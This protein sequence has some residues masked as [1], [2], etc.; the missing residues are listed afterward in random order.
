ML[1]IEYRFCIIA[2]ATYT[3]QSCRPPSQLGS[4]VCTTWDL[5]GGLIHF[6][7]PQN[8]PALCLL[9]TSLPHYLTTS[10]PQWSQLYWFLTSYTNISILN[11]WCYFCARN[12]YDHL[13]MVFLAALEGIYECGLRCMFFTWDGNLAVL[14]DHAEAPL[15]L[16]MWWQS[17]RPWKI[18]LPIQNLLYQKVR[19]WQYTTLMWAH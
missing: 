2:P 5:N 14:N 3:K 15:G 13:R 4:N 7:L 11:F 10:L 12:H 17:S 1:V 6:W 9:A 8:S 18:H 16:S 19:K